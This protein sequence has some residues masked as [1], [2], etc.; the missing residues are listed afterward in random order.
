LNAITDVR[1]VS[2]GHRTRDEQGVQTGVTV[3]RPHGEDVYLQKVPAAATV[4]NGFGKSI[5]LMQV[6]ELGLLETPIA[7]TNTFAVGSVANAQIRL[8]C[9]ANPEIGRGWPTVN[10]LVFECNDGYLNDIQA[11]AVTEMDFLLA[12]RHASDHFGQGSVGA[13]RGMSCFGLK[14]GIGSASRVVEIVGVAG[15]DCSFTVGALVLANFGV[16]DMLRVAGVPM[17]QLLAARLAGAPA[18]VATGAPDSDAGEKGSIIMIIATDAPL[19]ANQLRRMSSRAAAGLARCGSVY[20]HGS[21]DVA[22]AFST[23]YTV[24]HDVRTPTRYPSHMVHPAAVDPLFVA[25]AEAV[26]QAIVHAV[27]RASSVTGRDGNQRRCLLAVAPDW[28][29]LMTGS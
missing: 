27:W 17:G 26:E 9:R 2:V 5:G 15:A 10:P 1:G 20:G 18:P 12:Y 25:T 19:D 23:A 3:I 6:D 8:A 4:I 28:Q 21:G 13:G 16:P 11:M 22:L 24:S 7:L 14:G 29:A